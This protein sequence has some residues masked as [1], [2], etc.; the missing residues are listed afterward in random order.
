MDT[1]KAVRSAECPGPVERLERAPRPGAESDTVLAGGLVRRSHDALAEVYRRHSPTV[2]AFVRSRTGNSGSAD[3]IVQDVFLA[4]WRDPNR[5]DPSRGSLR[6]Y[7]L[8][9][10]SGRVLDTFRSEAARERR[11]DRYHHEAPVG[12]DLED[13]VVGADDAALVRR[14]LAALPAEERVAIDLAYFGHH[15]YREVARLLDKPE[16]TVKSRIR[17][18]L[19]RL[20]SAPELALVQACPC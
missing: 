3:D 9:V 2:A 14:S 7:L 10:A 18:G 5:F 1:E 6:T 11:Q 17:S 19:T 13:S 8:T 16:G 4:L 12:P 15:T 20:R